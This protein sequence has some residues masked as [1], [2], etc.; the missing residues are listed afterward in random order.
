MKKKHKEE[1]EEPRERK[2]MAAPVARFFS[3]RYGCE[4][5]P[6][7]RERRDEGIERMREPLKERNTTTLKKEIGCDPQTL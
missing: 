6:R 2:R 3:H 4:R 1:M 5:K 7:G